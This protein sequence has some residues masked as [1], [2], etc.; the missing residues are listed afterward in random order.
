M[1]K[2]F[3][4]ALV[5]SAPLA[6][7]A[8]EA[9]AQV[10]VLVTNISDRPDPND[11]AVTPAL[12]AIN[13][14][15]CDIDATI[16]LRMSG[17]TASNTWLDFWSGSNCEQ[18]EPR[19]STTSTACTYLF[20]IATG[21]QVLWTLDPM[22]LSAFN[23][24]E[25]EGD[26][27]IYILSTTTERSVQAV[28]AGSFTTLTLPIDRTA[29]G[30]PSAVSVSDGD[31]QAHVAWTASTTEVGMTYRVFVDTTIGS[32]A[33]GDE[34]GGTAGACSSSILTAGSVLDFTWEPP[35]GVY[36][37][38]LAAASS[39]DLN[40]SDLGMEVGQSAYV[41]VATQDLPKNRSALSSGDCFT[42]IQ[43]TGFYE[44]YVGAGGNASTCDVA[45]TPGAAGGMGAW[46]LIAATVVLVF[47]TR[48]KRTT[49]VVA[50]GLAF[51]SFLAAAPAMAQDTWTNDWEAD[52]EDVESP[53]HFGIE[54]RFGQY[55]PD[56][57]NGSFAQY[58]GTDKGPIWAF[59]FDAVLYRIPYVGTLSLATGFGRAS[60]AAGAIDSSTGTQLSDGE[61]TTLTLIPFSLLAV[62]R[63]DVLAR[64]FRLPFVFTGKLGEDST[65]WTASTGAVTDA[66]GLSWGLRWGAQL[67][68]ELDFFDRAAARAL[69]EQWGINH[70]FL[71]GEL[72]GVS[73][74][75]RALISSSTGWVAGLGFN[76]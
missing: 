30:V 20:S 73:G 27:I 32:S 43:T 54:A 12:V 49:L 71:F 65:L 74:Q 15:E 70:A 44:G 9:H 62:L 52:A 14:Y 58:F 36:I 75:G 38:S 60:Y 50:V 47:G 51:A 39:Y 28:A 69:D 56:V 33:G 42:R 16:T 35:D 57:G 4:L 5:L 11:A 31:S 46:L 24:C 72:F 37:F 45:G 22:P 7:G 68:I 61:Q 55:T 29:P 67:G 2:P 19:T 3:L 59:E 63:V 76:M 66:T 34:D 21:G 25:N 8:G 1:L 64:Q 13:Q 48:L 26:Q 40:P 18:T 17:V 10:G 53:E 41:A 23:V 6:L